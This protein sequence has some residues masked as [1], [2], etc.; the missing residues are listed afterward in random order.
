MCK[1]KGWDAQNVFVALFT[2]GY[3]VCRSDRLV[4]EPRLSTRD[5]DYQAGQRH[6][7][8]TRQLPTGSNGVC[9][10]TSR[11]VPRRLSGAAKMREYP[12]QLGGRG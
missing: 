10:V 4:R 9:A 2:V 11:T 8:K 5:G 12:G 6:G 3:D 1:H 7:K